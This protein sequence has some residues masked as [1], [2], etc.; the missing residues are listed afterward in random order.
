MFFGAVAREHLHVAS[1][2][3]RAIEEF[4]REMRASH[5]FAQR[6]VFEISQAGAVVA[7]RKEQIPKRLGLGFGF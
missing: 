4:R 2:R 6:R 3:R 7:F 5:D 1:V